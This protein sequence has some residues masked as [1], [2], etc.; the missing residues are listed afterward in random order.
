[1]KVYLVMYR[2]HQLAG[3]EVIAAYK[4]KDRA[5]KSVSC[6]ASAANSD[7]LFIKEIEVTE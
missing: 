2:P 6:T 5:E 7:F 3:Y 4:N 1:M